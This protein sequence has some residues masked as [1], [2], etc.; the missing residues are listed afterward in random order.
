[1]R[2]VHARNPG[3]RTLLDAACGTGQ[4]LARFREHFEHCEGFD[5]SPAMLAVAR[6]RLPDTPLHRGDLRT[7]RCG[8][9]DVVTCLFSAVGYLTPEPELEAGI[10]NLAAQ[11]APGGV[12]VIEPWLTR[13]VWD[14]NRSITI[15]QY[16][17]GEARLI[18][19][20][21]SER[22]G[23]VTAFE[24]HYVHVTPDAMDVFHEQHVLELYPLDTTKRLMEDQGL[25]VEIDPVGL[26]G[27]G[28]LIG[29]RPP[30]DP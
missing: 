15:E 22:R 1:M 21:R 14:D 6:R 20:T 28:L 3:A 9:F 13:E 18:R 24:M 10:A 11:L 23:A 30:S 26:T 17:D 12:L 8:I 5:L 2:H 25:A 19:A 29:V 7:Q 4:H 16:E 27:R